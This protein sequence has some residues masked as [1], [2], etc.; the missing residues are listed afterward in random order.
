MTLLV[1]VTSAFALDSASLR[2]T[3]TS[4]LFRDP[5][6]FFD[7]PGL[8]SFEEERAVLTTLS[9]Y[10]GA[11]RY[12][13]GYY[14]GVGPGVFGAAFDY[15]ASGS[16]SQST[17]KFESDL[18]DFEYVVDTKS[19]SYDKVKGW[20]AVLSYGFQ[21]SDTMGL[22]GALRIQQVGESASYTPG[23]AVGGSQDLIDYDDDDFGTDSSTTGS[24]KVIDRTI[25]VVAGGA[26]NG[27]S[28][29]L[30][31]HAVVSHVTATAKGSATY[32][33]GD[34]T[35]TLNG[36][37]PGTAFSDNRKG[38]V[39]GV[40][41]EGVFDLNDT[42]ALRVDA[43][44]AYG[45][46]SPA[47][48]QS[49]TINTLDDSDIGYVETTTST[50]SQTSKWSASS[51]GTLVALQIEGESIKVRPGLRVRAGGYNEYY[52][53]ETAYEYDPEEGDGTDG[54][55]ESES[56]T[57]LGAISVGLPLAVEVALDPDQ[58][59]SLRMGSDW[60]WSRANLTQGPLVNEDEDAETTETT[61]SSSTSSSSAL[62][63]AFGLRFWPVDAFRMDASA[64]AA[65]SFSPAD[66]ESGP[67]N[68]GTVWL[69]ATLVIP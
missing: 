22:G 29:T 43:D 45:F 59:W 57:G 50:Y 64:F 56:R 63:G 44:V 10:G 58:I 46:G 66:N 16:T 4:D 34:N 40:T 12:M 32:V 27:D 17:V 21:S 9:A 35:T 20:T 42:M 25:S 67:F 47:V 49:T 52:V 6:D 60:S 31:V 61:N 51:L 55:S 11:G 53:L 33:S 2:S 65:S 41:F 13:L 36:F 1:L 24:A 54:S 30:S 38:I 39:P 7:Q 18:E 68:I 62:Q 37:V 8:L 19:T 48:M 15:G 26:I 5:Y 69:S 28:S 23:G 3:S 14:G